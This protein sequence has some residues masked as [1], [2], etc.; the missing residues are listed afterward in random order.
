[1]I[2]FFE[3]KLEKVLKNNFNFTEIENL[4]IKYL[5]SIL[6]SETSKIFLMA[7]FFNYFGYLYEFI[8][9]TLSLLIFRPN[10]GGLHFNSYSKCLSFT[11]LFSIMVIFLNNSFSLTKETIIYLGSF[12]FIC[13]Y[14]FA[15]LVSKQKK[16]YVTSGNSWKISLLS[17]VHTTLLLIFP[18]NLYLLI[19][20]W[21]LFLQSIQ[22]IIGRGGE[23]Y[24]TLYSKKIQNNQ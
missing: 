14:L 2:Y 6:I 16:S 17:L 1:M 11:L 4:K 9:L 7:L 3:T 8:L 13:I 18:E 5:I 10:I 23:L 22:L 21:A 19:T 24:E 15:P 12:N 20:V